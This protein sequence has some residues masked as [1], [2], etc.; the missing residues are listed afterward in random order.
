VGI[1]AFA[2]QRLGAEFV[3]QQHEALLRLPLLR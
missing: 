3:L 2:M 1:S